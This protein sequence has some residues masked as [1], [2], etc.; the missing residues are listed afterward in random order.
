MTQYR[1]SGFLLNSKSIQSTFNICISPRN[2]YFL[3]HYLGRPNYVGDF[4]GSKKSKYI[5]ERL[6]LRVSVKILK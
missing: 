1:E 6:F 2:M 3:W 5:K 4:V